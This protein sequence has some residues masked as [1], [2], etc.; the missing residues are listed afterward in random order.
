MGDEGSDVVTYLPASLCARSPRIPRAACRGATKSTA[1]W[2]WPTSRA[3]RRSPNGS[4]EARGRGRRAADRSHQLV[5]REDAE[6]GRRLRWRHPD[7]RRRRDPAAVRRAGARDPRRGRVSRDAQAGRA[8]GRP[9]TRATARSRSAC[10]LAP[11]AT[12]SCSRA[13]GLAEVAR[14]SVRPRARGRDDG[15]GRGPGRARRSSLS[16]PRRRPA[17]SG[18]RVRTHR[19]L[20][21]GGRSFRVRPSPRSPG[22]RPR[23]SQSR[24]LRLLAPFLPPYA[25][26]CAGHGD[27]RVQHHARAPAHGDR[28]CQHPWPQR[29]HRERRHRRR[30]RALAGLLDHAHPA[31]RQ[32]PRLR[33]EQRHRHRRAPSSSSPS[34][35]RWPTSTPQRTPP[36]LPST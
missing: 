25:R 3:S 19:R 21:E 13:A 31:R 22:E 36:A 5:L 17:A 35:R 6:D 32:A 8:R 23:A 1:P 15:A 16:Q 4:R 24:Q 12:R 26:A 7:L 27:E 9:S 20:L 30:P 10:R 11:T 29:D 18:S 14:P 28:L 2:S 33:R 34:G